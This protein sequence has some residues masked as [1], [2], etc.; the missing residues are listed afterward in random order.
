M[1]IVQAY[2][3]DE[4]GELFHL[5]QKEQYLAHLRIRASI[6]AK[7]KL[8]EKTHRRFTNAFEK[9]RSEC[10]SL[11]DICDYIVLNPT[12]FYEWA[13]FRNG[14]RKQRDWRD[15]LITSVKMI[16][17]YNPAC[18]NSHGAPI[19][20]PENWH[21][22]PDLP[23][24]FPGYKGRIEFQYNKKL[25]FF[26]SKIFEGFG[27]YLGSG[28]SRAS[29]DG[30]NGYSAELT[31]WLQDWPGLKSALNSELNDILIDRLTDNLRRDKFKTHEVSTYAEIEE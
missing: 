31:I 23:T 2:C 22:R 18:S 14:Q 27:M 20:E 12:L 19:G 29:T 9:M 7:E 6:R 28:G 21:R 8:R 26:T 10:K 17:T 5:H 15:F 11:Q 13:C 16:L 3:C 4:T 30:N 25:P 1:S 24:D